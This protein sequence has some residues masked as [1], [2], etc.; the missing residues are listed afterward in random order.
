MFGD[1]TEAVGANVSHAWTRPGDYTVTLRYVDDLGVSANRSVIITVHPSLTAT[2]GSG[3][4]SSSS[5]AAPG[6]NVTFTSTVSNGTPP[7]TVTW[8][9]GDG[10]MA[11]GASVVHSYGAS[12]TY[13]VAV[14]VTDAV[15]ETLWNNLTVVVASPAAPSGLITSL[16]GG[17][18]TGLF[19]GLVLGGV[20]AAVV[21]V[22]AGPRKGERPP[23][24]PAP[25]YVPP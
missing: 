25:P 17:F 7:Y 20:L 1:G 2:F 24:T 12:G 10:S 3:N 19:L 16:G 9:F 13:T 8:S 21:L 5:P 6:T 18:A 22:I 4:V 14:T 15:G 11:T 23:L